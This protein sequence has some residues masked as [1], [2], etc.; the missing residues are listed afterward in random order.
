MP[1]RRIE[2]K[3]IVSTYSRHPKLP[4]FTWK[5]ESL[6]TLGENSLKIEV[7]RISGSDCTGMWEKIDCIEF[8]VQLDERTRSWSSSLHHFTASHFISVEKE[9]KILTLG[10]EEV[11]GRHLYCSSYRKRSS[12]KWKCFLKSIRMF[13]LTASLISTL[14]WKHN[15]WNKLL[16]TTLHYALKRFDLEQKQRYS[17]FKS[18]E[19]ILFSNICKNLRYF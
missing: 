14:L 9:V 19:E 1:R 5:A 13:P 11:V 6:S 10:Q 8:R 15:F 3:R 4:R 12:S 18:S 7:A 16:H 2:S 17:N